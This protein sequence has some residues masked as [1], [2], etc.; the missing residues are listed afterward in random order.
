MNKNEWEAPKEY[1]I[2]SEKEMAELVDDEKI[3]SV[4]DPVNYIAD[5]LFELNQPGL[6][7]DKFAREQ[8]C[9]GIKEQGHSYGRWF[10]YPWSNSLVRFPEDEDYYDLRT[11]RNKKL[12]TNDEQHLLR[13]KKIAAFGLSVG[14]NVVDSAV[15]SG[16]GDQ[17]LLFDFDRLTPTNLNRI[18]AGMGYVGLLKTTVA[19]RKMAELDPYI[20]QQH[21]TNGYDNET[22]DILRLERPDIIIEEVDNL[23]VKARLRKIASELRVPIV[24]AG[25]VDDKVV[26]DIERHDLGGV[27]PFNGKLSNRSAENLIDS[28]ITDKD[29]EDALIRLLGLT[30]LSPRLVE[31]GMVRGVEL[32]GFPQ[33]GT[34]ASIGGAMASVAMR[35]I[36]LGRRI[37]S[38]SRTHDIRKSIKSGRPT[39]IAEDL[40]IIKRFVEY[41]RKK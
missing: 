41:R 20:K 38:G 29:Q 2:S 33:L 21:F 26:L 25:D 23:E 24:T 7:E 1:K 5:D 40:D 10:H 11:F 4:I 19:G 30:N 39:T 14:S 37:K 34:T 16:I 27:R 8:F 12:I 3:S 36:L 6:K 17:Y 28:D 13:Q 32:S 15:Q 35:D 22:D 18:R 9:D 31:S